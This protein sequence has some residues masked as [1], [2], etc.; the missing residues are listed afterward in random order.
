MIGL[1]LL[2]VVALVILLVILMPRARQ[3]GQAI[4][5]AGVDPL[6]ARLRRWA[7]EGLLTQEQAATI[8]AAERARTTRPAALTRPVSVVVELLGYLGGILAIIGAVLLA[9]RFWQDLAVWTRLTLLGLVAAAVWAAGAAVHE[10]TDPA[11]WRLRGVLWLLSSGAVAFFAALFAVDVLELDG[12]AVALV[13]GLAVAVYA[14]VLW[15]G[16]PRPLQQLACLAGVVA[17]TGSGVAAA[18]G[19]QTVVG[20]SIWGVGL[21][22]VLLGWRGLLP[23]SLVALLVGAVVLVFGAQ[24]MAGGWEAAGLL[25]GLASAVGLLV[26][27]TTGRRL[28]L[29]GVGIL[30]VVMFL[31]AT[32]VHFFAGTVGVPVLILLAGVVLL[33]VTVVLLGVRLPWSHEATPTPSEKRPAERSN[34]SDSAAGPHAA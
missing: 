17:A 26:A 32:V 2:V 7:A 10:H 14:G 24:A 27:G 19:S 28:A 4:Q 5:P 1:A 8:L 16:R 25:L 3:R 11:L 13:T 34:R 18:G 21:G 12:E 23:P 15:W 20:L 6:A 33:T 31:P 22:W 29:A 9:A 30:G